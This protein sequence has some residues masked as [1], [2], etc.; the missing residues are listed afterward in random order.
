M[1]SGFEASPRELAELF[2]YL[3]LLQKWNKVMNL[4]GPYEW[5]QMVDDLILDSFH[6]AAFIRAL[7]L[8]DEPIVWDF[9]A[10]AGLPGIPLRILWQKGCYNMVDSRDKRVMFLQNVLARL[11]LVQT[12]AEA[13]RVEKFM[14]AAAPANLLVSRAFMPWQKLLE[15]VRGRLAPSGLILFMALEPAPRNLPAGYKLEAEATYQLPAGTRHFWA[16]SGE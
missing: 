2:T 6:L 4:V 15:L 8:P 3:E 12:K 11:T 14:E 1:A 5:P 16:I 13:A 10:G 9:G 7:P